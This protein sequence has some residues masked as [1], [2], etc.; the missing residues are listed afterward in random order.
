MYDTTENVWADVYKDVA[1]L[2]APAPNQLSQMGPNSHPLKPVLVG[3]VPVQ[4][5]LKTSYQAV[6]L[7][8]SVR[9][10]GFRQ[11]L[12]CLKEPAG[13]FSSGEIA[14]PS[15]YKRSWWRAVRRVV[16][17]GKAR[18]HGRWLRLSSISADMVASV[19]AQL[20]AHQQG[21][22]SIPRS[23]RG[24]PPST[25]QTSSTYSFSYL[26]LNIGGMSS[27]KLAEVLRH[28]S[29]RGVAALSLQ[30]TRWDTTAVWNSGDWTIVHSGEGSGSQSYGGVLFAVC[31]ALD[32]RY[33]EVLAGRILRVQFR[34]SG[35]EIPT[36]IVCVYAPPCDDL[37]PSDAKLEFRQL[38]W[39]SLDRTL[40]SIPK[41]HPLVLLGDLNA[42]LP[43]LL[44]HVPS[45]DPSGKT[46]C[47]H[48][49]V[50]ALLQTHDLVVR[51]E[52]SGRAGITY[53]ASRTCATSSWH[54][55]R[56]LYYS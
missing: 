17:R 6:P 34:T 39:Q 47:D 45:H 46:S 18:Y 30:E 48:E 3:T 14:K 10:E 24:A 35:S 44:P 8:Y 15:S 55:N 42:R 13:V 4:T 52:R 7:S 41:R 49:D 51:N 31:G 37:N 26:S 50:L 16:R 28:S 54:Q 12:Q 2:L 29:S 33:D 22:L 9:A 53:Q 43:R 32:L 11:L 38:I 27:D 21:R 25:C 5:M 36:E 56:L 40:S 23:V 1:D 20:Q 19:R